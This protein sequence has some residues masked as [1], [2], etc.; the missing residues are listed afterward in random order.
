MPS[1]M[2]RGP[3]A[4][5]TRKAPSHWTPLDR[6]NWLTART[7]LLEASGSSGGFSSL[8]TKSPLLIAPPRNVYTPPL[9]NQ[10][11]LPLT[12]TRDEEMPAG[13]TTL[14]PAKVTLPPS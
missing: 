10:Q 11:W 6:Q 2:S 14:R 13:T 7:V 3:V 12:E 1:W 5:V 4:F 8:L 9:R